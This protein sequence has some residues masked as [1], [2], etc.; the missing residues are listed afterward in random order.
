MPRATATP[1]HRNPGFNI[2][3]GFVPLLDSAPLIMARELGF[4]EAE[5]LNVEL[6]REASWASIRDKISFG[7]LDGAQMLAPM[8]LAMSLAHDRPATPIV[9]GMVLSRNGNG[10][11]LSRKLHAELLEKGVSD[12]DPIGSAVALVDLAKRRGQPI[13]LA[14]VAPWSSH[15]LQLRDWLASAGPDAGD[16]IQVIPVSPGQMADAFRAGAIEGCCVGEPWNSLLEFEELGHLLHSGHQIWQNSPEKVLGMRA[17]WAAQHQTVH[18][19]L[20]RSLLRACRWLDQPDNHSVLRDTLAWPEYLVSQV[21]VLDGH[22]FSLFHPRLHQHFFRNSANFPW[23]SQAHWLGTRLIRW[24]Q[25][26]AFDPE[27]LTAIVQPA[28]FRHA[29]DELGLDCPRIDG[30]TEGRHRLPFVLD[31]RYGPVN[32]ASDSLLGEELHVWSTAGR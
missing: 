19:R 13:G 11:T 5:G 14:S 15:D 28:L 32:V 3:L 17:D 25:L 20:I 23:V 2:K 1:I 29:A 6:V 22:A 10:I 16:H 21:E 9:T 12:S 8:P 4:F 26:Q 18:K 7:L 27:K 24:G 30:K 31:G